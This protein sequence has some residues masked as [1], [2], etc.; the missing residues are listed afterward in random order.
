MWIQHSCRGLEM[1]KRDG[2][3]WGNGATTG[4]KTSCMW[5]RKVHRVDRGARLGPG[6]AMC[7][8]AMDE[9]SITLD[10]SH[11]LQPTGGQRPCRRVTPAMLFPGLCLRHC[12][13]GAP[14]SRCLTAACCWGVMAM[15][16]T[17]ALSAWHC[18]T[19]PSWAS[20]SRQTRTS[21]TSSWMSLQ[22]RHERQQLAQPICDVT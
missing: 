7:W 10:M 14:S 12:C 22:V 21:Q 19:W 17:A 1:F 3:V 5:L 18:P 9:F 16:C 11:A 8:Q 4:A 2:C 15:W 6:A 13:T 20:T